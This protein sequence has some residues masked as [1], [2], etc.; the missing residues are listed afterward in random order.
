MTYRFD[1]SLNARSFFVRNQTK[2]VVVAT[3]LQLIV[4]IFPAL[5]FVKLVHRPCHI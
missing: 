4:L 5:S 3:V 1:T 2:V